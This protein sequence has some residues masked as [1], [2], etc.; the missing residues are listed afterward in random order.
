MFDTAGGWWMF[1][2]GRNLTY[3]T[4]AYYHAVFLLCLLCLMRR[5]FLG[6]LALAALLSLSHP[7]V[8]L[9]LALILT[10]Y[11]TPEFALGTQAASPRFLAGSFAILA[12]HLFYYQVFLDRFADHR[13]LASQWRLAW[14]YKPSSYVP[15]LFI[16]AILAAIRIF[17]PP[18]LRRAFQDEGVRLFATWFLVVFAL[19]QRNLIVAPRQPIHFAHGYDWMAL[20][21]I[22]APV[23]NE[24]L[25]RLLRIGTIRWRWAAVSLVVSFF[26][27]DN[28]IWYASFFPR[29]ASRKPSFGGEVFCH[30]SRNRV[31][32]LVVISPDY[33]KRWACCRP[34]IQV[35]RDGFEPEKS[36]PLISPH[37][38]L[39][40]VVQFF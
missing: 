11:S 36:Y 30:R 22:C 23:L 17:R 13:L 26:L 20:F 38:I 34:S 8:G 24:L 33:K 5:R 3:P 6:S 28:L 37:N 21:F 7:F 40:V 14:L 29:H 15:A 27:Q 1:N 12:A 25:D 19:T 10:C 39:I 2:F 32:C 35:V 18:G 4:E 16:V 9:T 31:Q